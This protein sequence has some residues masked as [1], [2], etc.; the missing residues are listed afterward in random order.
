MQ[1]NETPSRLG[2]PLLSPNSI[3][4]ASSNASAGQL[5]K[6]ASSSAQDAPELSLPCRKVLSQPKL[7]ESRTDLPYSIILLGESHLPTPLCHSISKDIIEARIGRRRAVTN[8]LPVAV[9]R[10]LFDTYIEK[11]LPHYPFFTDNELND[12][13]H[14]VYDQTEESKPPPASSFFIVFQILAITTLTSKST[15]TP[16]VISL[17][18]ALHSQALAYSEALSTMGIRCIQCLLLL[19]QHA[20]LSP[21]TANLVHLVNETMRMAMELGLHL[22][23]SS[24]A[25]AGLFHD[26]TRRRVFWVVSILLCV[27]LHH[28]LIA[29]RHMLSR[30]QLMSQVIDVLQLATRLLKLDFLSSQPPRRARVSGLKRY[31]ITFGLSTLSAIDS[32]IR[33]FAVSS[34]ATSHSKIPRMQIGVLK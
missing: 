22:E 32:F 29:F 4:S 21:S 14:M 18:E 13:F 27:S 6:S 5:A 17:A 26:D 30:G 12:I 9:A 10:N 16:R 28:Q 34:S 2:K 8:V 7:L 11:V 15:N 20:L 19:I 23:V 1:S 24:S 3:Y 25:N 31:E 33:K